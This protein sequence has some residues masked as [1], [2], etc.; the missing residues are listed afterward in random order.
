MPVQG[1]IGLALLLFGLAGLLGMVTVEES[2]ATVAL[3]GGVCFSALLTG[4]GF[5]IGL[6]RGD[7]KLGT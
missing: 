2:M 3:V 7:S 4:V 6:L 1:L 5:V